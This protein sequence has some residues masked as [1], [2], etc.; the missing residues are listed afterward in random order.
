MTRAAVAPN[1]SVSE[2]RAT[3]PQFIVTIDTEGDNF[4][5][6]PA[7]PTTRNVHFLPRFQEL[8]EA[9]GLRPTYLTD[10]EMVMS[11]DF[12]RFA[13]ALLDRD[14][15]EIGMHLHGWHSPP[16]YSLTGDD[17]HHQPYLIEYPRAV[18]REKVRVLTD[19]LEN[20]FGVKMVSHRA[21]RWAFNEAYADLL[22]EFGYR[23][24]CSVT[25]LVSWKAY[26]GDPRGSGGS[27][28]RS[29]PSTSY[30]LDPGDVSRPG[31][32]EL[33]EVPVTVV[34]LGPRVTA[35]LQDAIEQLPAPVA[36]TVRPVRSALRVYLPKIGWLRPSGHNGRHLL[37]AVDRVLAEGRDYAEFML[38]SSELMPG[39]SPAIRSE[40]DVERLYRDIEALFKAVAPHFR[41]AT[42]AEYYR[43]YHALQH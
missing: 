13:R 42:L 27:D 25:P 16:E 28:Y 19:L 10:Y 18:M 15:A 6:K 11:A 1:S 22:R 7:H 26:L 21:G 36:R 20:T 37:R 17:Y 4:W 5:D 35:W 9:Y 41:G 32:S 29:F 23:V 8:C 31:D 39:G 2:A 24:D 33:L 34:P 43:Y 40:A 12:V 14:A 3:Q 30:F 38:H